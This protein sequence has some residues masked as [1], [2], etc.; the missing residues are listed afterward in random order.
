MGWLPRRLRLGLARRLGRLAQSFLPAERAATQKTL[1][2]MTGARGRRL[3]ELTAE[4]FAEFAMCFSDLITASRRPA[5]IGSYLGAIRGR[6][7]LQ[8]FD[9]PLISLTAHVGN[10][11]LAGRV[12]AQ[13][14]ARTTHVV[15]AVEEARALERWLRRDGSGLRFVPRSHP[16]VSLNLIAAL[17]RGDA[18]ALQGD[19][20]LGN[21]GDVLIPFFGRPAPFP[22][23]PFHLARAAGV[24]VLPAFCT[25]D[26]DGRYVLRVLPP[27]T[28]TRGR[29]EE[30][31]GAW[32]GTLEQIVAEKPTQWFNFFDVWNPFGL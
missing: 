24:P 4:V 28:I 31:L 21:R 8:G 12:L 9:G 2:V 23:G 5:R 20:A 26:R 19:R 16:T 25:L 3:D 6:E 7:H 13:H 22:V 29:E 30:A 15:V 32:V 14:S 17:R 27:M 1:E 11:E 18:V 10:W